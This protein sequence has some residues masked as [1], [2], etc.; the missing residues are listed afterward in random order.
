MKHDE[1]K[2]EYSGEEFEQFVSG[3]LRGI[4]FG[5]TDDNDVSLDENYTELDFSEEG[6]E[7]V[8]HDCTVFLS[9]VPGIIPSGRMYSAGIDYYFTRQGHGTGFW[10][11]DWDSLPNDGAKKLDKACGDVREEIYVEIGDDGKIY[12]RG[13]I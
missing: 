3:H 8:K 5:E 10:D 7:K 12:V 2:H 9:R 4:L 6:L 11:G 1:I 13:G